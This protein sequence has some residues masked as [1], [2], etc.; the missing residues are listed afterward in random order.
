GYHPVQVGD[1]YASARYRVLR[2]LGWGHFSTVW[3][4]HDAKETKP[5]PVVALKIVK[6]AQHYTETA[7]D[8]IKLLE[9]VVTAKPDHRGR[10]YVVELTDWFKVKGVNGSHVTMA[11]EVLGPNLLT[12]IR[13][14]H[15]RGIPV[16]IVKRIMKQVLKGLDYLHS[17]CKI[18]HTD[19]KPE[20]VLMCVDVAQTVRKMGLAS[21]ATM[22]SA[23]ASSSPVITDGLSRS[24]KKKLKQKAKK[25]A[26]D[27]TNGATA[28]KDVEA[29]GA[30]DGVE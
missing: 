10:P 26:V 23:V 30:E 17:E 14:Y 16:P 22:D 13:Q 25:A 29:K 2:K 28:A 27:T 9:K 6:S 3:L 5:C 24:Q 18:I 8:E 11:F 1:S 4:A 15:H 12:L 19:L 20:N 21:P 7:L